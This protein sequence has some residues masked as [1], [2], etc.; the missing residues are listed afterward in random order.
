[1]D[2]SIQLLSLR[3]RAVRGLYLEQC[4][5]D[6]TTKMSGDAV[7]SVFRG[8]NFNL[9]LKFSHSLLIFEC[10]DSS[11]TFLLFR[12]V[13]VTAMHFRVWIKSSTLW[14]IVFLLWKHRLV[15]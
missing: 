2:G 10:F 13:Q 4:K 5:K 7:V 6:E 12:N 15:V 1:M 8:T 9:H 3:L 14:V 11:C